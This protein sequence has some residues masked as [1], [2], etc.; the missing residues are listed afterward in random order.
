MVLESIQ[1]ACENTKKTK[2]T[3]ATIQ[4]TRLMRHIF[5]HK[6]T[7]KYIITDSS[8]KFVK[9][10]ERMSNVERGKSAAECKMWNVGPDCKM[11]NVNCKHICKMYN[12]KTQTQPNVLL[13]F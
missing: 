7:P 5:A 6:R 3:H 2:H 11:K 8:R 4:R 9:L 1:Y 10:Q 13:N 12:A